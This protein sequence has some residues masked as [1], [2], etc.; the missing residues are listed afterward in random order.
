VS[1]INHHHHRQSLIIGI[2]LRPKPLIDVNPM[3]I[4][5]SIFYRVGAKFCK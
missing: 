3:S 1:A 2:I 5:I 4:H